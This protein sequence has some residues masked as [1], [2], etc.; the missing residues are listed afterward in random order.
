MTRRQ[1]ITLEGAEA[2]AIQA[3]SYIAKDPEQFDR[4][5]ALTG[6]GPESLRQAAGE[7]N[8]LLGVLDHLSSDERLLLAFVAQ[9][10]IPPE[11]IAEARERLANAPPVTP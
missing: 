5:L 3:L 10:E 7:P 8:F 2:L 1:G 6:I 9:N 11:A 4:F